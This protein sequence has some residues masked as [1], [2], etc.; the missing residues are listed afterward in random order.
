MT[1]IYTKR[2]FEFKNAKTG[3]RVQT[4]FM[5][6]SVVPDWAREDPMFKVGIKTGSVQLIQNA[7]Q[8]KALD[9]GGEEAE[10]TEL[11]AR[12]VELK[13]PR[14]SQMGIPKLKEA[15]AAAEAKRKTE[16]PPDL[17]AGMDETELRQFAES[18]GIDLA[19]VAEG[20]SADD[21]R[22]AIKSASKG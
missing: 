14:A 18:N 21:L 5:G 1:K 19:D 7:E 4:T 20:A 22:A 10:L 16:D 6:F 8:Q 9:G 2:A 12:A 13:I 11:R 17:L 3:E 15:I